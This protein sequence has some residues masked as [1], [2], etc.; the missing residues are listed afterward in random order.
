[1]IEIHFFGR[2]NSHWWER[3][4]MQTFELTDWLENFRMGKETFFYL[5]DKLRPSISRQ[6]TTFR[7][8]ISTERRVAI[9]LW[10]LATPTEYRTI[11][12]LFGVSRAAVCLIVQETCEVIVRDL[13]ASYITFPTGDDMKKVVDGFET[14]WGFPQC[15]GA[16]DGTHIPIA[17][18]ALN[19][20]DY[21]NRKGWY[22]MI[23][24]AVVDHDYM[25]RDI[26]IG[27]PGSVHDARVFANSM[28]Y[29]QI[30]EDDL[31]ANGDT[32][33]LMGTTVPVC[34]IGDSAYPLETWLMKPFT[35]NGNLIS[36]QQC[37]NYHLSRARMVVE[38]A[39]GRLKARWRRLLK[40]ND[41]K[42]KHI[43][44]VIA[45]CC[46]LH[47]LCEVHG[48]SFNDIWLQHNVTCTQQQPS[49]SI[50]PSSRSQC[51]PRAV[52]NA[53]MQYLCDQE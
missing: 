1:M 33:T 10:C 48:E 29:R 20:S 23:L 41:M 40:R 18:P 16:I 34:I 6:N 50:T 36:D 19:H 46:V 2:R 43:P 26:C 3:I 12:H 13:M 14:R 53:K 28:L 22:S 21:Y 52:R 32:R 15:V 37:F 30:M 47:N 51:A 35:D 25:F 45:A 39:F 4:V 49:T 38:N 42:T 9:T 17:A 27:W 24:Q 31:L 5:C 44:N 11:A 8:A 7:N